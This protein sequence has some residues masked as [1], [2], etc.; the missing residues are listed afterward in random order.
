MART[1]TFTFYHNVN[2]PMGI[3]TFY[4]SDRSAQNTFFANK[5]LTTVS[6]C[7]YQRT[8]E[9]KVKIQ[10]SY[11]TMYR[12]DYMSFINP[13]YENKRFYA[14]VTGVNY[15]DDSTTEITYVIDN[16]QTWLLDCTLQPCFI[17]RAHSISDVF[18]L[19][20]LT[21]DLD[22]GEYIT[23]S[24]QLNAV[25]TDMIVIVLAT[26]D[27]ITWCTSDYATK[28][29]PTTWVKDGIYDN[30]SQVGFYC[31]IN[32]TGATTGSALQ[33]FFN[34]VFEGSGGVTIDDIVNIYIYPK[35]GVK[36]GT[37]EVADGTSQGGLFNN[38][39]PV[40]GAYSTSSATG[41]YG[42]EVN[43]MI[44]PLFGQDKTID[45]YLPKN[46]KLYQYP[47]CVLHVSN[48][49]GS[50]IDYKFERFRDSNGDVIQSPK[51]QIF[52][53]SCG[54]AKIRL[55]PKN[56]L[57]PW[58]QYQDFDYG[59]DSG[60][61]PTVTMTGDAYNI[62][63]AQNKNRIANMYNQMEVAPYRQLF[64]GL[65]NMGSASVSGGMKGGQLGAV[66]GA[67]GSA[68]SLFNG[69]VNTG[70]DTIDK[71]GQ[72]TA[73][74]EDLKIAPGTASGLSGVGMSFQ[75]GRKTF[76]FTVKTIDRQH[77]KMI[78]DYYTM[79]GYPVRQIATPYI[80]ARIGFTYIKTCGCLITGDLPEEVKDYLQRMFDSGIRFWADTSHIGDYSITNTPVIT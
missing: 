25:D 56:Y 51:A 46:N 62:Y 28:N 48:N 54:D 64:Q 39:Y 22:T 79:F 23:R 17:D 29:S 10:R 76:T 38:V 24:I 61:Y 37:G 70:F 2:L 27:I 57:S 31:D 14:F 75:N 7:Y 11:S 41:D 50:A 16:I 80:H 74:R 58:G 65:L 19:N 21:D 8:H 68:T 78:D 9:G 20:M 71:I 47:Y 67:L 26:F 4:F 44:N 3:D 55:V 36:F 6:N 63:L 60:S 69:S 35:I 73:Q 32:G 72:L 40:G 30:L 77:A 18:G 59:I 45:G 12:C 66:G 33:V 1:T 15:I 42:T 43:L 34:K 5:V 52:G 53:T 49:D 13:D